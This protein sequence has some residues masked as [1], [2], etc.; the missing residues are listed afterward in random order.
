MAFLSLL[1]P[2][3]E[4]HVRAAP[5]TTVIRRLCSP[6]FCELERPLVQADNRFHYEGAAERFPGITG[7]AKY[8]WY[9]KILMA[10]VPYCMWQGLYF[11]VQLSSTAPADSSLSPST[12]RP[13]S[14][15]DSARTLLHSK[16]S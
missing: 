5:L 10:A 4:R 15:A 16:L 3:H 8:P 2:L 14:R 11:K 6:S 1:V 13:R 7:I 12:A 9:G